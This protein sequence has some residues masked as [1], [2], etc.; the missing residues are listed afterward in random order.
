MEKEGK[1]GQRKEKGKIVASELEIDP[2]HFSPEA[3]PS[4]LLPQVAITSY[5]CTGE[6][7]LPSCVQVDVEA[8][9]LFLF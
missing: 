4:T 1:G 6:K 5:W 2:V 8:V 9:G 3:G 7:L